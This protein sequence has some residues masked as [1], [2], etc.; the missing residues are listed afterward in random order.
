M[1]IYVY[2]HYK[3]FTLH[4]H[5][6]TQFS[7]SETEREALTAT[8]WPRRSSLEAQDLMVLGTVFFAEWFGLRVRV[9]HPWL[10]GRSIVDSS[11]ESAYTIRRWLDLSA[12]SKH[13]NRRRHAL[14]ISLGCLAKI[15][16]QS[17]L[18]AVIR[19][20]NSIL[21]LSPQ[22]IALQPLVP[23]FKPYLVF[24]VPHTK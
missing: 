12:I 24:A 19:L 8:D 3:R 22:S 16:V 21:K 18:L 10:G 2:I 17:T 9:S 7:T 13:E 14:P 1:Q 15:V 6:V 20:Y 23:L 4:S 11:L 5:W